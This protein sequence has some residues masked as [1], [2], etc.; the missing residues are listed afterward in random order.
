MYFYVLLVILLVGTFFI[1]KSGRKDILHKAAV[2]AVEK[3]AEHFFDL[4]NSEKLEKAVEITYSIIPRWLQWLV[5]KKMLRKII[6]EAYL[7]M[8]T[9]IKNKI[10]NYERTAK[11]LA[12]T[13]VTGTIKE[14]VS[15]EFNGNKNITSNEQLKLLNLKAEDKINRIYGDVKYKTDFKD[16]KELVASLGFNKR[17]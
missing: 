12:L 2:I 11:D 3:V 7:D 8:K 6:D 13:A 4:D 14:A 16:A 1:V 15:L 9:Y 10:S 5:T 17:F